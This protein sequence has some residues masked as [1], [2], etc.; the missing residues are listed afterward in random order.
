[1]VQISDLGL[2]VEKFS[3]GSVDATVTAYG[4]GFP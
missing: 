1:M 4:K 3:R 2:V